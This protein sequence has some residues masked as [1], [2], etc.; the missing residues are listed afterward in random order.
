MAANSFEYGNKDLTKEKSDNHELALSHKGDKISYKGSVYYSDFD[1]YI[2]NENIAKWGNLY[3]RRYNQ[4]T[5][6]FYGLEGEMTF[7][8]TPNHDITLFG[9]MV[10]GK[11]RALPAIKG[12]L[13]PTGSQYVYVDEVDEMSVDEYGDIVGKF[14]WRGRPNPE[15]DDAEPCNNCTPQAWIDEFGQS[16]CVLSVNTYK[17]GTTTPT[18]ADYDWLERPATYALLCPTSATHAIW[19]ALARV[20]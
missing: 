5:A 2:F 9:D 3:I 15:Y 13:V 12:K 18:Q 11:I 4:T 7:H 8:A 17:N 10:R 1:N 19:R 16:E 14:D 20:F 6:K